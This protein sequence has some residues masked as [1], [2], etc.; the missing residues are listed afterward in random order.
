M[1]VG[2]KAIPTKYNGYTFRSRQEAR[3]AVFFDHLGIEY[4]YEKEGFD[5]PC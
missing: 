4:E 2:I 5:L 1:G 3:W